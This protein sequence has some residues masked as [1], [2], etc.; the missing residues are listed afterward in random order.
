M[1]AA[2]IACERG[3]DSRASRHIAKPDNNRA[4]QMKAPGTILH[5]NTEPSAAPNIHEAGG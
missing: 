5:G 3:S 2:A 1:R 4:S